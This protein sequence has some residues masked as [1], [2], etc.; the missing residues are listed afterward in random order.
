MIK[1]TDI[2]DK[3]EGQARVLAPIFSDF[4]AK[5]H[6]HGIAVTVECVE[7][8]SLIKQLS[9]QP[10]QGK[11]LVVDGAGSNNCALLGDMIAGDLAKNGW[12]GIVINGYV[13]DTVELKMIPL[14]IKALGAVPRR[15]EKQGKGNV[16]V[17]LNFAKQRILPGEYIYLD[18]DG[19]VVMKEPVSL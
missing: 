17:P 18:D 16:Y 6:C 10:G 5:R 14:V 9:Q 1:T 19:I 12:L 15:S 11:V 8:N 2:C 3:F 13:R 4:G 7:D